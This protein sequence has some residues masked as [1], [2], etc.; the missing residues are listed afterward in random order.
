VVVSKFRWLLYVPPVLTLKILPS[1]HTVHMCYVCISEE[2]RACCP[3]Q[4]DVAGDGG[5]VGGLVSPPA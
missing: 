2:K 4:S 3:T 1:A 5:R